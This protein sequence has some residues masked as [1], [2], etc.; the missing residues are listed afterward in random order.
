MRR[1]LTCAVFS[2]V[3]AQGSGRAPPAVRSRARVDWPTPSVPHLTGIRP[4]VLFEA[5][6]DVC[7]SRELRYQSELTGTDV[8]NFVGINIALRDHRSRGTLISPFKILARHLPRAGSTHDGVSIHYRRGCELIIL[9]ELNSRNQHRPA[10]V[11]FA[12]LPLANERRAIDGGLGKRA[13]RKSGAENRGNE[14]TAAIHDVD[15]LVRRS[16][17]GRAHLAI[18]CHGDRNLDGA[19]N[20]LAP[21]GLI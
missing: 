17:A 19:R 11:L 8:C 9:I 20:D 1:K 18:S 7:L 16:V 12:P 15:S 3:L 14:S 13:A 4:A 10:G 5:L 2:R 21:I 6:K